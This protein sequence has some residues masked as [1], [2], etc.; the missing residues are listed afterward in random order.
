MALYTT[1]SDHFGQHY[2]LLTPRQHPPHAGLRAESFLGPDQAL[3]FLRHLRVPIDYWQRIYSDAGSGP[4]I[5]HHE[6][7]LLERLSVMLHR[8][9]IRAYRVVKATELST[10]T[11]GFSD[12][13]RARYTVMPVNHLLLDRP[14]ELKHFANESEARAFLMKSGVEETRLKELLEEQH[15]TAG[16]DA[17]QAAAL[18]LVAG[19]LVVTVNRYTRPPPST[20]STQESA[21]VSDKPAGLGPPPDEFK[22][23]TLDVLDEFGNSLGSAFATLFDG[24]EY[25]LKTDLGEEHKGT[26]QNGKIHIQKAKM[27]R[28][29]ELQFKDMPAFMED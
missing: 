17:F 28:G 19:T 10:S 20:E 9:S 12:E 22:E 23:I 7:Q 21:P 2:I 18:A 26:I 25:T 8:G 24:V 29:F 15:L 4:Q 27:S 13:D 3:R 5:F 11:I 1:L 6:A 16:K 14:A